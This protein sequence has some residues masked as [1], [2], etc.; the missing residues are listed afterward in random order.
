[1]QFEVHEEVSGHV[2]AVRALKEA[3]SKVVLVH[4]D[5][6]L[7]G[8]ECLSI[9]YQVARA[10][11]VIG[12]GK[13]SAIAMLS[14]NLPEAYLVQIAGQL[15]GARYTPLHPMGSCEDQAY[16]IA[17]AEIEF[18]FYD[19]R[20]FA[21][22]V[23]ELRN[24]GA[25]GRTYA[26]GPDGT[27][28]DLLGLA[29]QQSTA[30]VPP[31]PLSGDDIETL[32]YTGGTTGK[33]KGVMQTR[34]GMLYTQL[35]FLS[36]ADSSSDTSRRCTLISTPISHA[37]GT[38]ITPTLMQGGTVVLLDGFS[39]ELF[40]RTVER[41][42]IT[43]AFL[44]PTMVYVLLDYLSAHPEID[45]TSL[46]EVGYGAAPMS[47]VRLAE[48]LRRIGPVFT[49]GYGQTEA[50]PAIL[51]LTKDD[52]SL[53]RPDLLASAGRPR[54]GVVAVILRE[55]GSE[56][57]VGEVGELCLRGPMLMK[58]YWKNPDATDHA[59]RGGWLH[60]D[61]LARRDDAGYIT[62]VDRRKDMIISGGF[63]VYPSEVE[64]VL[65]EHPAV[66]MTAVVGVPD[67]KWGE[68]VKAFVVLADSLSADPEELIA[69]VRER[70]GAIN[71]PKSVE[72]IET[73]PL[74]GV[75]KIDRKALR[76]NGR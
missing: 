2:G 71:T 60:T 67:E 75:G 39:A 4:D 72:I 20:V 47:P 25:V 51:R 14:L 11:T 29:A 45:V 31:A 22:R 32:Y 18:L 48:A 69:Y 8:D 57:D 33:P 58:G 76:A 66:H 53:E 24:S 36:S 27:N 7:T 37:G 15:V 30:P 23:A 63:N 1:M 55:D 42:Q 26:L 62:I 54:L 44:V 61:D 65:S 19:P 38:V 52:H 40:L 6:R 41:E 21:T 5:R 12:V 10:F 56:A 43:H 70:K 49:Q 50:G 17:D 64:K 73:L 16:V 59:F 46:E 28:P 13:G 34:F 3:G 9:V 68:S 74:T 35:M